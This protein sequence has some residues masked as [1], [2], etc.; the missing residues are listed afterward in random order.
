L[1]LRSTHY[2]HNNW[3]YNIQLTLQLFITIMTF[4]DKLGLLIEKLG[5]NPNSFAT[6]IGFTSSAIY[7]ILGQRGAKPSYEFFIKLAERFPHIDFNWFFKPEHAN[8]TLND[9]K[10]LMLA[11][12][13]AKYHSRVPGR[14]PVINYR[15]AAN[16]LMGIEANDLPKEIAGTGTLIAM[17]VRGTSMSP[18]IHDGSYVILRQMDKAEWQNIRRGW[19]YM[20][21]SELYGAQIKYVRRSEINMSEV[22][23]LWEWRAT[24]ALKYTSVKN[25]IYE[26]LN[27]LETS[28][29]EMSLDIN[30]I[31]DRNK[32]NSPK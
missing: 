17:Q 32:L 11:E 15:A 16:S 4:S 9:D 27:R 20:V 12:P 6:E 7:N 2:K 14:I 28:L 3:S 13:A 1:S 24:I 21:Y 5:L 26:R 22:L 30:N 18:V 25:S 19:I 8:Y 29:I 31:K 23:Q 10:T